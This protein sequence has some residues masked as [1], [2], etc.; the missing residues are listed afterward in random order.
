MS[1]HLLNTDYS[2]SNEGGFSNRTQIP[3]NNTSV[4]SCRLRQDLKHHTLMYRVWA[5]LCNFSTKKM[6]GEAFTAYPPA[7]YF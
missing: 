2:F 3:S 4:I 5:P 7:D 6:I 1:D